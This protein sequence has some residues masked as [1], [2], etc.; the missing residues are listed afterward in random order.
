[1]SWGNL[2]TVRADGIATLDPDDESSLEVAS[3]LMMGAHFELHGGLW[4]C[5]DDNELSDTPQKTGSWNFKRNAA[6]AYLSARGLYL[7]KDGTRIHPGYPR[8]Y[9]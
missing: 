1:M 7:S 3:A 6:R 5:I 9:T 4:T 2:E 8:N